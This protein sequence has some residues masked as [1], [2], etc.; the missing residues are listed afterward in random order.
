MG[1]GETRWGKTDKACGG[2]VVV[3][4]DS[5]HHLRPLATPPAQST[6]RRTPHMT[7]KVGGSCGSDTGGGGEGHNM[8]HTLTHSPHTHTH[9]TRT[10]PLTGISA[11]VKCLR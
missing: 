10:Q 3:H 4:C 5:A 1:G 6:T 11:R 8:R 2:C 7:E 9:H